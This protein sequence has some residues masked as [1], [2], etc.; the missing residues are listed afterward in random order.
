MEIV[1]DFLLMF[2]VFHLFWI[3]YE[4]NLVW[5][6]YSLSKKIIFIQSKV[7]LLQILF[8]VNTEV[9]SSD[10]LKLE[11]CSVISV[12]RAHFVCSL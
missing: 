4:I 8:L 12:L 5:Y 2:L 1:P 11:K 6:L 7:L 9:L 3:I 10:S